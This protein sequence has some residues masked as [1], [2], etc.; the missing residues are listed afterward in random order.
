[1]KK[2]MII[3]FVLGVT[4]SAQEAELESQEMVDLYTA[5]KMMPEQQAALSF[6]LEW[7][8]NSRENFAGALM[9]GFDFK[10]PVEVTPF[11]AGFV[12]TLNNN[13]RGFTVLESCLLF[14]WYFA[15]VDD[16]SWQILPNEHRGFFIQ[17]DLGLYLFIEDSSATA[18]FLGGLRS[19]YRITRGEQFFI[20]PF[21]RLGYPFAFGI[22]AAA[23]L[24]F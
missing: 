13:F 16:A 22:G 11:A 21:G 7:T 15:D 1:M 5:D 23:G 19:G 20:E 12:F 6:G 2:L 3:M 4:L 8:M 9:L 14:R 10:L 17:T 18:M 24:R